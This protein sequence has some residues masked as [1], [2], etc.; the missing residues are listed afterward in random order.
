[1]SASAPTLTSAFLG[2]LRTDSR[3]SEV[4]RRL[5]DSI[6]LGLIAEREQ[7]PS[8]ETLAQQLEVSVVTVR[9]ALAGLRA[10]GLI[11]T[12]RGRGG[13]SFVSPDP[14]LL[15][16]EVRV[17]PTELRDLAEHQAA[18]AG[19][20]AWLAA[21]KASPRDLE[22]LRGLVDAYT[23]AT[24]ASARVR[25]D[26]GILV[27]LAT[28]AQSPRLTRAQLTL[29]IEW[30]PLTLM[31]HAD[32][33]AAGRVRADL[34]DLLGALGDAEPPRARQSVEAHIAANVTDIL[35][36]HVAALRGGLAGQ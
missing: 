17:S 18:I 33:H 26:S 4:E 29:Q 31:V 25:A 20:S 21:Q 13:G 8:E 11:T 27:D 5:A 14:P 28:V 36:A 32:E 15:Q 34:E 6:R 23:A 22:R 30:A 1:M 24:A 7:L 19:R 2:P 35:R 16:A 3:R 12:R 9:E 10:R